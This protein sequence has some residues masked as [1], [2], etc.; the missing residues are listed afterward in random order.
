MQL[1]GAA[2]VGVYVVAFDEIVPILLQAESHPELAA[3]K[4]YGSDGSA[5]HGGVVKNVDAARF[6]VKTNFLNPIYGGEK[7]GRLLEMEAEIADMTGRAPRSYAAATYDALWVAA[8]ALE[9]RV[10]GGSLRDAFLQSASSYS[11]VTGS[12]ELN[13]A[14]DRKSGSYDLWAVTSD[15]DSFQW[16]NVATREGSGNLVL[17]T[18]VEEE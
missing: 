7:T 10:E 17:L 9:N 8:L 5:Q 11:G 13:D 14:G 3:V 4:W 15:D 18:P 2:S 1:H 12:T 6:A 16:T